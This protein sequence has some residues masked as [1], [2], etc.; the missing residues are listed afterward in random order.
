MRAAGIAPN[1]SLRL[2]I[3]AFHIVPFNAFELTS[4]HSKSLGASLH[5]YMACRDPDFVL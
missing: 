1:D 3:E 2:Y 5:K 4:T